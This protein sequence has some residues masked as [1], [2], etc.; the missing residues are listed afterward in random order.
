MVSDKAS[1][2]G[3]NNVCI[4]SDAELVSTS[5]GGKSAKHEFK[6]QSNTNFRSN[7]RAYT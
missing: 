2:V 6:M 5:V 7:K 4:M 3:K 1:R